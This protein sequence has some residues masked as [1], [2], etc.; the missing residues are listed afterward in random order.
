M[1]NVTSPLQSFKQRREQLFAWMH[2]QGGGIAILP[3][4]S[5]RQRNRDNHFT[6]RHDSDFFYLSGFKESEAWLVLV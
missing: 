3:T 4:A 5:L 1:S 6:F 2:T